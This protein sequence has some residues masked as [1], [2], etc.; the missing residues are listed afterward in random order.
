MLT[1]TF[2]ARKDSDI[3]ILESYQLVQ[4]STGES[5]QFLA[6]TF[7]NREEI[8][9]LISSLKKENIQLIPTKIKKIIGDK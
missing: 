4:I 7:D 6:K 5:C 1:C 2:T 9:I 3:E 8:D